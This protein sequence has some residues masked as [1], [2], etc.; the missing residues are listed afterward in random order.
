MDLLLSSQFTV[1]EVFQTGPNDY[2]TT[3]L[4]IAMIYLFVA[5]CT[6]LLQRK[7]LLYT[8]EHIRCNIDVLSQPSSKE[9]QYHLSIATAIKLSATQIKSWQQ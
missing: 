5:I 9:L 2:C 8:T 3:T 7:R 6:T 1:V 4:A